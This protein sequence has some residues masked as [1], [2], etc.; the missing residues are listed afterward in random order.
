M[1]TYRDGDFV[2]VIS[3]VYSGHYGYV[4]ELSP[5]YA[6]I[7]LTNGITVNILYSFIEKVD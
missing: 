7:R 6:K 5:R 1:P 2:Q 4:I 3:G